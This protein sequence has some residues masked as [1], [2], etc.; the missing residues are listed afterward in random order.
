MLVV[1]LHTFVADTKIIRGCYFVDPLMYTV[2]VET[3]RKF[4]ILFQWPAVC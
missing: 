4:E 2:T 1:I 3:V